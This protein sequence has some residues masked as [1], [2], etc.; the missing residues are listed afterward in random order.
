MYMTGLEP[1]TQVCKSVLYQYKM[2]SYNTLTYHLYA[3]IA[4]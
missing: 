1:T 3:D 4:T 2:S